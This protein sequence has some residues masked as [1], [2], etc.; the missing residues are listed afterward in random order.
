MTSS[1]PRAPFDPDSFQPTATLGML[2]LRS[3]LLAFT[4][5]CFASRGYWEVETPV[6]S[7]DVV[8]DAYLEP[9]VTRART[10]ANCAKTDGADELFLQTSPEFGMKRLVAAGASAIYQ[11]TRAFRRGEIGERHN[12]EFTIVEWYRTGSTYH[13]QMGFV[14]ELVRGFFERVAELKKRG[15]A[16]WPGRAPE[17]LPVPFP[18]LAY[19]EAFAQAVGQRVLGRSAVELARLAES[20]GLAAP[21]SLAADDVDGWLN[22]ILALRVEPVLSRKPALFLYDYPPGQA[23]LAQIHPGPPAVAE[24]FELYLGGLEICNGY[25]ELTDA[26]E[27]RRRIGIQAA[28]RRRDGNRPLP[29]HGRLLEAMDAGL[30]ECAGVA[31]GFD[32]LLMAAVGATSLAEVVAFPFDRA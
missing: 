29:E 26:E 2:Q 24:R 6:L 23:A 10:G 15:L 9:F 12:P 13:E 27:L 18:R 20:I 5:A 3:E 22:L 8:V 30:P 17:P 19:D 21:P 11:M 31:L 32:R 7:R 28:L 16:D 25:Q 4:R 1:D 14:E